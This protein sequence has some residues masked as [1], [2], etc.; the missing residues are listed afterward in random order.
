[1]APVA[2]SRLL[3]RHPPQEQ[4]PAAPPCHA[5]SQRARPPG[6]RDRSDWIVDLAS[7]Q[8]ARL[9]ILLRR[10]ILR[11]QD[12]RLLTILN[13]DIAR[14][15]GEI[16][17][18]YRKRWQIELLFRWI[19]QH[20][21]IRSFLGRSENAIRLQIFAAMIAYLLLRIAARNS[22]SCLLAL[23]FA[24]VVR[25]RLFERRSVAGIDKS[26]THPAPFH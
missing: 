11:R 12:G 9:P 15:A 6:S 26:P 18:L 17:A 8:Q 13:K 14:P 5:P 2:R 3:L 21:K 7:Q 1:V 10:I 22:R 4:R 25:T 16:A 20:L 24:D 19:K 23:R